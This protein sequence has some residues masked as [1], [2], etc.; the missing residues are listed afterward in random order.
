MR[1]RAISIDRRAGQPLG[2]GPVGDNSLWPSAALPVLPRL[3]RRQLLVIAPARYPAVRKVYVRERAR[4][5][6]SVAPPVPD[7][8][9]KQPGQR[10]IFTPDKDFIV[11]RNNIWVRYDPAGQVIAQTRAGESWRSLFWPKYGEIV[12][13]AADKQ[14]SVID[15]S[16]Y[17]AVRDAPQDHTV[18]DYDGT[19]S[20]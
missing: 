20:R 17:I 16:G 5:L 3:K 7:W 1:T 8:I 19:T 10:V 4:V 15:D 18:Y 11:E 14:W 6:A 2:T 12:T 9:I 13:T